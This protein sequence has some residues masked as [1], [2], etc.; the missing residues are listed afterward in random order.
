MIRRRAGAAATG[1]H[2]QSRQVS[3]PIMCPPS[4]PILRET[5]GA[6]LP[7]AIFTGMTASMIVSRAFRSGMTRPAPWPKARS[8]CVLA[9]GGGDLWIAGWDSGIFRYDK[10]TGIFTNY[11]ADGGKPVFKGRIHAVKEIDPGIVYFGSDKGLTVFDSSDGSMMTV[12]YSEA[13]QRKL[14]DDFVYDIFEDRE[15]GLWIATYFGGVCYSNPNSSNF[16]LRKCSGTSSKGKIISKFCENEGKMWIGTDDGGLFLYDPDTDRCS[17]V[18]I[19][20]AAANLNIHAL[21]V[22]GDALL[23]GTYGSGLYKVNL[24]SGSVEHFAAFGRGEQPQSIYSLYE[25]PSGKLW[26][27]TKTAVWSWTER[28][29]FVL[30][31]HLGYNS[32]VIG[33]FPDDEGN[34]YF[35]SISKGLLKYR[36]STG[37]IEKVVSDGNTAIP[38]AIVSVGM[39]QGDIVM[40]TTGQ[41]LVRY[42]ADTGETEQALPPSLMNATVYSIISDNDILWLSTNEGLVRYSFI[43]GVRNIYGREDGLSSDIFSYNSGIRASDGRIY[44][45]TNNGFNI[46]DPDA[47]HT[48]FT[49]PNTMISVSSMPGQ[50]APEVIALHKGHDPFTLRFAGLSYCSSKHKRYRYMMEGLQDRWTEVPYDGNN[51]TFQDLK[52][53]NYR[54][55]VSS[56]NNDGVWGPAAS[57]DIA[58]K[59]YWYNSGIAIA[60]YSILGMVFL[61]GTVLMMHSY[62]IQIVRG[63]AAKIKHIKERTR[64][65]TEL[66]FFTDIAHEIQTPVMLIGAPADELARMSGLPEKAVRNISLIKKSADK[67][68]SLTSEILEF[69]K[70]T[71]KMV[72]SAMNPVPLVKQSADEFSMAADSR[73]ISMTFVDE[74]D[75][76]FTANING[77]AWNRIMGNILSNAIKFSRTM[78]EIRCLVEDGRLSVSVY[79]D[80]TGISPEEADKIF[81]AFWH[82]DKSGR[83]LPAKG[84]GLG[85]YVAKMLAA[86]MGIEIRVESEPGAYSKFIVTVPPAAEGDREDFVNDAAS[87]RSRADA[88]DMSGVQTGGQ[89]LPGPLVN[90]KRMAAIL[91]VDSDEDFCQYIADSLSDEFNVVTSRDGEEALE[92]LRSGKTV[93]LVISDV[94]MAGMDGMELCRIMKQDARMQHIPVIHLSGSSD[95][96][97]KLQSIRSGAD[98]YVSKPVEISYLKTVAGS[99]L[100]KRR[101]LWETFSKRP[102][103]AMPRDNDEENRFMKEFCDLVMAHMSDPDLKMEFLAQ[104]MHTSRTVMF[105][106]VKEISGMTPN[107]VIKTFRLRKAAELLSQHK[108]KISEICWLVGFNTPS[109]FSKCF[110]EQFGV[111]PKDL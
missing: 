111:Y 89:Q 10:E 29:G 54:F 100:E 80:G 30:E 76:G 22:F 17:P 78:V 32:D 72:L 99:V 107:N 110:Y 38:D 19:D 90:R 82:S 103:L 13:A 18:V 108:Y 51:V 77:N 2:R 37:R 75:G 28:T 81:N 33:I 39:H 9:G 44:L 49:A 106:R 91:L 83:T 43:S 11:L 7:A 101:I 87:V 4:S 68:I 95:D 15:G 46:F 36:P 50:P 1:I 86:R 62:N 98:M 84:F 47:L 56:C 64:I 8:A 60:V 67:L 70:D 102:F 92:V 104:E 74:T 109:Y 31:K 12:S 25:S 71:K 52:C 55:S 48:N 85:L 5:S 57:V 69:R 14:S 16:I 65:E 79:D 26:I 96:R 27:G 34:I 58:V 66:Q 41:G 6:L 53:G 23:I 3:I 40:G 20:T 94:M 73:G 42:D 97:Q 45:G 105:E 61:V 21:L 88:A 35:A 59:P 24:R 93:D 63:R